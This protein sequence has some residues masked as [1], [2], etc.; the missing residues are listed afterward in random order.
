MTLCSTNNVFN[1]FNVHRV[2][3]AVAVAVASMVSVLETGSSGQ[4]F[5]SWLGSLHC[6]LV[7]QQIV[8]AT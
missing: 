6:V 4:E 5:C 2:A 8:G 3:G 1:V 7:C